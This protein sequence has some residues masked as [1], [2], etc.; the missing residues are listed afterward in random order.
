MTSP[1]SRKAS[2][3]TFVKGTSAAT[4]AVA[5]GFPLIGKAK[6]SAVVLK[7]A[8]LAPR[9]STWFKALSQVGREVKEK[10]PVVALYP[11][12]L[13]PLLIQLLHQLGLVPPQITQVSVDLMHLPQKI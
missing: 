6:S 4:A 13:S 10:T 12:S 1:S 5:S 3:R 8:T 9:G 2:R 11:M 7:F